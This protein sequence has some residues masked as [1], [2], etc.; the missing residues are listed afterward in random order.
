MR[1]PAKAGVIP[2]A[3][4]GSR[5][6]SFKV[7]LTGSL[8]FARDDGAV[9]GIKLLKKFSP[10]AGQLVKTDF[11]CELPLGCARNARSREAANSTLD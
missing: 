5:R 10:F 4:E 6:G 3:I 1:R 9:K 2:S 7:T 11:D 8:D